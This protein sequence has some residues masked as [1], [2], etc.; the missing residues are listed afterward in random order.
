ME[1]NE[2]NANALREL[3]LSQIV[4]DN[5][6]AAAIFEKY[7]LDFCC[8]GNLPVKEACEQ[9]GLDS[10]VIYNEL[11]TLNEDIRPDQKYDEWN[12]DFL[13]DYIV[14]NHHSYILRM[15]PVL[16]AHTQKIAAV[17]GKNHPEL[18]SV[19]E[20]FSR[21]YKDLRQHMMK[22]EQILFPFIK[23]LVKSQRNGKK[24]EAPFFGSVRNPIKMMEAEH[25]A[26][27][28]EMHEIRKLTDNY[29]IPDDACNTY[30]V[31]LQELKEFEEDLHK[32]VY[33]ENYIL[34]P[35]SVK[36]ESELV[37]I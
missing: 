5:F 25:Q 10:S 33:L 6:R 18:L 32:H 24:T 4:N 26:A 16:S 29:R 7:N 22:E 35:K 3:T 27:G 23:Q 9:K 36:L 1:Q 12:L 30:M 14:N 28:D 11:R 13:I 15:I 20:S 8:G 21:V 17:H 34:F 37:L 2:L 31:T 19:A